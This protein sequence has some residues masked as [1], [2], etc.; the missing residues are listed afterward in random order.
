MWGSTVGPR[1]GCDT[2]WGGV[3]GA[4]LGWDVMR[5]SSQS[6]VFSLVEREPG[7][8]SVGLFTAT[9]GA[10]DVPVVP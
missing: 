1:R 6:A 9:L 8:R 7:P 3:S 10:T 2:V 4:A 5:W